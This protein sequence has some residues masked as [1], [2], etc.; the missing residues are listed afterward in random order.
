MAAAKLAAPPAPGHR[1]SHHRRQPASSGLSSRPR[2]RVRTERGARVAR[3][4][5]PRTSTVRSRHYHWLEHWLE[6]LRAQGAG[7]QASQ[8]RRGTGR[9]SRRH[10]V[11]SRP[12]RHTG[13]HPGASQVGDLQMAGW[14]LSRPRRSPLGHCLTHKSAW[15]WSAS[16]RHFS[17]RQLYCR[18]LSRGG[19]TRRTRR[20]E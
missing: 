2:S 16:E 5:H 10:V 9:R 4:A 18:L 17:W 8:I 3:S 6:E 1:A 7:D 13:I 14:R 15:R 19:S 12:I 11:C 20:R